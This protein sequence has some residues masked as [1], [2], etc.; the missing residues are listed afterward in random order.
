[1]RTD[2]SPPRARRVYVYKRR[3]ARI[4]ALTETI[5][6]SFERRIA[7]LQRPQR[8]F[9]GAEARGNLH[10]THN[11]R[12]APP[13]PQPW[14]FPSSVTGV[15]GRRLCKLGAERVPRKRN[16]LASFVGRDTGM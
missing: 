16:G 7:P 13:Q 14:S 11:L 4:P 1:M 9:A 5:R 6:L 15:A 12:L 2:P 8:F 3:E 10:S